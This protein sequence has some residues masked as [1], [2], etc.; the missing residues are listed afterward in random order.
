V[1]NF[2]GDALKKL[3]LNNNTSAPAAAQTPS[4]PRAS[5][6]SAVSS[7]PLRRFIGRPCRAVAGLLGRLR[8]QLDLTAVLDPHR[9]APPVGTSVLLGHLPARLDAPAGR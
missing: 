2:T 7:S 3:G 9:V 8:H 4:A 1:A 5:P 6:P